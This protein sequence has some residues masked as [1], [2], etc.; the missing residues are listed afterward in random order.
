MARLFK[1]FFVGM[2]ISALGTLPLGTLNII[3]MQLSVAEGYQQAAW[4]ALGVALVEVV[5]VRISLVGMDWVRKRKKL[6]KWLDWIALLI[7]VALAI[8]SFIA[9]TKSHSSSSQ[10]AIISNHMN[11]FLFGLM[12]SAINPVQIPFWFGWSTV[13]FTKKVLEPDNRHYNFYI[14]G[15][16]LG[17]LIGHAVFIFGGQLFAKMLEQNSS[18]VNYVVGSVF[19]LTAIIQL[20]KIV[21][22]KGI[23]DSLEEKK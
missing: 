23:A 18:T 17:T 6:F 22:G 16:G 2:L 11:R 9:A 14:I 10:N 5:Y 4:F 1:I 15:I 19:A 12:M 7:V 21:K 13:L 3:S 8:T 20:V